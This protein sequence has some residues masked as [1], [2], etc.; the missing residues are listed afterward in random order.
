MQKA[1]CS[2]GLSLGLFAALFLM[3]GGANPI[4]AVAQQAAPP[5]QEAKPALTPKQIDG[6]VQYKEHT[7]IMLKDWPNLKRFYADDTAL[8][9]PAAGE[10]RIVFMGDSITGMGWGGGG[11]DVSQL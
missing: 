1:T 3:V 4:K 8:T 5:A 10:H 2:S 7:E 11:G 6:L 9:A